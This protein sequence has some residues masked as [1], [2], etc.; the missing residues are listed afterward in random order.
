MLLKLGNPFQLTP[1]GVFHGL[2]LPHRL[3]DL[4]QIAAPA[5]SDRVMSQDVV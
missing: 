3:G 4:L 5:G 1:G 2:G